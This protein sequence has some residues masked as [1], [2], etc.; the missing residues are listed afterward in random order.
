[1]QL[2]V[3]LRRAGWKSPAELEGRRRS[4]RVGD[5]EMPDE[6]RWIAATCSTRAAARSARLH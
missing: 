5:E 6:V 2:Y 4:T 3:I 1:M